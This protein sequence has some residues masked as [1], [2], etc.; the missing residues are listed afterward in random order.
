MKNKMILG[1]V[2]LGINYGINNKKG[3]PTKAEAFKILDYA[4]NNGVYY[5]DTASAYGESEQIIGE[6]IKNTGNTFK[7]CTKL[8]VNLL[9]YEIQKCFME[10][11][12]RLSVNE[13]Y[14]YY[15]HRFEQCK[16]I[17]IIENLM[18]LKREHRI[19]YIGISI[20]DPK[21]LKYIID[22][23]KGIIEVIQLP[24][25][26][27]DNYRWVQDDLLQKAKDSGFKIFAR[28][29]YLQ[30]LFFLNPLSDKAKKLNITNQ[31]KEIQSISSDYWL[32][33]EELAIGYVNS[34]KFID[35]YL[36][37]CENLQQLSSNIK[38]IN[39][40]IMIKEKTKLKISRL[41]RSLN[42]IA[43]DPRK[44]SD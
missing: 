10:S 32:G 20:Y 44:W 42:E 12:N 34:M 33:I 43:I 18:E 8:P 22:N 35:Q 29:V 27:F 38:I 13:L 14:V 2:Q 25:N 1:T 15:L 11:I 7:I 21:E 30:G 19:R 16:E 41:S 24:F 31:L 23:L 36:V 26:L 9:N 17:S 3:K 6:Y 40:T 4:F 39:R 28:S 5:L 37:G